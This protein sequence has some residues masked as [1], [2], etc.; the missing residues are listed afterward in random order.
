MNRLMSLKQASI[1][2]VLPWLAA[3]GADAPASSG[4]VVRDSA[5]VAIVENAAPAWGEGE[6]WRV[7]AE[8]AVDIGV[9]EGDSAYEFFRIVGAVRLSDG[10]IVVANAG[11]SELRYFD[12]AGRYLKSVGRQGSG[13][14]EFERMTGLNLLPGDS[15]LVYDGGLRRATLVDGEGAVVRSF[16]LPEGV[17]GLAGRFTGGGYI[18]T[19]SVGFGG[20]MPQTGVYQPEVDYLRFLED[21]AVTDT[22]V[23]HP[24]SQSYLRIGASSIEIVRGIPFGRTEARAVSGDRLFLANTERYDIA[25]YGSEGGLLRRIRRLV[26]PRPVTEADLARF[27]EARLAGVEEADRPRVRGL[28]DG[29]PIPETFPAFASLLADARG[30]LWVERYR[31]PGDGDDARVWTVFDAEG[32]M[33]G[34]VKLPPGLEPTQIGRDYVLGTWTDAYDIQHVR[35]HRLDGSSRT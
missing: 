31:G 30:H 14:G 24:G 12:D 33:L 8:P 3:C 10:R 5:G 26:E 28:Y 19:A 23:R 11:T 7:E 15:L 9:F 18:G 25:V 13:P 2:V 4:V 17:S 34:D 16:A 32:R 20:E 35:L 6:G 21:G 29:I 22:I 1:A 27:M